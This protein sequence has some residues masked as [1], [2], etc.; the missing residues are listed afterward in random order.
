VEK[1]FKEFLVLMDDFH[2]FVVQ[3][4][5]LQHITKRYSN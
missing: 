1:S 2:V 4:G 5:K 3:Q